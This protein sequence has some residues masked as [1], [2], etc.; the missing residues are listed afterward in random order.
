MVLTLLIASQSTVSCLRGRWFRLQETKQLNLLLCNKRLLP[1]LTN[2]VVYLLSR[3]LKRVDTCSRYFLSL[4]K[5]EAGDRFARPMHLAY[6]TGVV[7][8]LPAIC[9]GAPVKT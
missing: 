3:A 2:V 5:L 1:R 6:E 7:A 9:I 4:V 8:A